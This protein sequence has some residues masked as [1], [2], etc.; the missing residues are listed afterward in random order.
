M[1]PEL[2]YLLKV[3]AG[4]ALFYAF[5][6]LFCCRDTF[7]VWR[8]TA[9]LS[10]LVLSFVYP[11]LNIQAWV[12]EQPAISELADY[13]ALLMMEDVTAPTFAEKANTLPVPD[14][15]TVLWTVYLC[16]V[17]LLSARFLIQQ[18][19]ILRMVLL[20]KEVTVDGIRVRSLAT[21]AN[22]FS[23]G[24]WIFLYLPGLEGK[25]RQEVLLHEGTHVRQGHSI[26]VVLSEIVNILCWIN[27]FSWLLKT[28]IRLN[29]EY[30]ADR[31]VVETVSDARPYQYHLLGL[32]N[33]RIQTGLYNYFNVSHLKN[34]I[35]MMN[36]ERTHMTGRI[37]YALFAP[38]AAA[39]L[40]VSN[41]EAVARTAE[42]IMEETPETMDVKTQEAVAEAPAPT[43]D[44]DNKPKVTYDE[45]SKSYLVVEEMPEFPGGMGACLKFLS[46]NVQYP[47]S[48][49]KAG[50]QGR[51]IIQGIV[52]KDGTFS[53]IKI[54][55]A[56]SPELDAE[57]IRVAKTMPKWTPGKLKGEA[58]R[59]K[60]TL[61][62]TF[63]L[64]NEAPAQKTERKDIKPDANGNYNVADHM[65]EYPGGMAACL[66]FLAD[67]LQ[68][69]ESAKKAGTQGRVIIQGV[70]KK[71]GTFTDIKVVRS[72]SSELDAE[73][74]RVAKTMPK[75]TP[76]KHQGETVSVKYTLPVTFKLQ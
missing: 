52:E 75:W 10:F 50:T 15:M 34:R 16:G 61:P 26:D 60:Y 31:K 54:V 67:N 58:V 76:G 8:R 14:L 45:K 32:A 49:K 18:L 9:L 6:K 43:T 36:K 4:I 44:Q 69:P 38:L 35:M 72:I 53:N 70:V 7:F 46:S 3:N 73:A 39:L 68:Y 57:A 22:P 65:P 5:Y 74:I 11:L 33:Q 27:P 41:I 66:K 2:I 24:R 48:A 59:C 64:D 47:E 17:V 19:S 20:S 40:L 37:K 23:F 56:V 13:Y 55:R 42:R 51:V 1:T 63:K 12:K 71:D 62:V 29:L 21:P 25:E 30:L 28:E